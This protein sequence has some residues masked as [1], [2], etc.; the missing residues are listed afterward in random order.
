MTM[1]TNKLI[2]A[3]GLTIALA[4]CGGPEVTA[5]KGPSGTTEYLVDCGQH[6]VTSG[7]WSQ[8]YEEAA[9]ACPSGYAIRDK[10]QEHGTLGEAGMKRTMLVACKV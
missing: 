4:G 5:L 2:I 7:G 6:G 1:K 3:T 9:K 10:N 8:C